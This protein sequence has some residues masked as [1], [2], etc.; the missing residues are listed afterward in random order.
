MLSKTEAK[1]LERVLSKLE[2]KL[3]H[4]ISDFADGDTNKTI[5]GTELNSIGNGLGANNDE[6]ERYAFSL[7]KRGLLEITET[8]FPRIVSVQLTPDGAD[9]VILTR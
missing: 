3:M 1:D 7:K 4:A 5:S 6:I 9:F 2:E 8:K